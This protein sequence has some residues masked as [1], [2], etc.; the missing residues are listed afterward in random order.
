MRGYILLLEDRLCDLNPSASKLYFKGTFTRPLAILLIPT[1]T[2]CE[3]QFSGDSGGSTM[4][5]ETC[6]ST[7]RDGNGGVCA[8]GLASRSRLLVAWGT[9]QTC[10]TWD[11]VVGKVSA[12]QPLASSGMVAACSK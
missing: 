12:S 7:W 11:Y 4:G 3:E 9:A 5:Q 8:G 1:E 2:V 6:F 10:H